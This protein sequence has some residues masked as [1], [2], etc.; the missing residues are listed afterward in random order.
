MKMRITIFL[1]VFFYCSSL[2]SQAIY[3]IQ[4]ENYNSKWTAIAGELSDTMTIFF[5]RKPLIYGDDIFLV[6]DIWGSYYNGY[7]VD[8]TSRD[9]GEK[10]WST[11]FK[12]NLN[13]R[14]RVKNYFINSDNE[15]E[16]LDTVP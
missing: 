7:Q 1:T 2:I 9:I 12:T 5:T 16:L 11:S 14:E 10:L 8:K 13:D 6:S 4:F 3:P 15:F